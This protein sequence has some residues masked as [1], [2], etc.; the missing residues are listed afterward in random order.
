MGCRAGQTALVPG[1][2]GAHPGPLRRFEVFSAFVDESVKKRFTGHRSPVSRVQ[3]G[4]VQMD[5]QYGLR[6]HSQLQSVVITLG[7][8]PTSLCHHSQTLFYHPSPRQPIVYSVSV[9]W[10]VLDVLYKWD[11]TLCVLLCLAAVSE[12]HALRVQ[13]R[14]AVSG[15]HSCSWL[16]NIPPCGWTPFCLIHPSMGVRII[17]AS[18]VRTDSLLS[19]GE[20]RTL[21]V[22]GNLLTVGSHGASTKKMHKQNNHEG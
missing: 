20:A 3:F 5:A 6:Q 17:S 16:H 21:P 11:P 15:L 19:S 12:H 18:G 1:P 9:D 8:D 14:V 13:P 4:G 22:C 7:R 2:A 10:P